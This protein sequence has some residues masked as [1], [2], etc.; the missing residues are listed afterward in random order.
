MMRSQ[1]IET[2]SIGFQQD[3]HLINKR[4]CPAGA[5]TVHPEFGRFPKICDLGIFAAQLYRDIRIR[6]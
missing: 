4:T 6:N 5:G 1:F 3:G 2:R